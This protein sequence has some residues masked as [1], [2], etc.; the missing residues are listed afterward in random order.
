MS[1]SITDAL[2]AL[3]RQK[4]LW[5][6][7]RQ[8]EAL[9]DLFHDEA[10]FVHMGA[11]LDKEQE[12]G[13]IASGQ[14]HYKQADI[15]EASARIIGDTAVVL[16]KL[17]LLAVVG[18]QEVINPFVVTEVYVRQG[19]GWTLLSMSFTKLLEAMPQ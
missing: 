10:V 4:W 5:M 14:I 18:G 1:D 3:S 6:A 9:A 11:T 2:L 17:K 16:H 13:V 7:D 8:T 12:M 19:E 15:E